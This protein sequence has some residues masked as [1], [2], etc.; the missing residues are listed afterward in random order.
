MIDF[1]RSIFNLIIRLGFVLFF[2]LIGF[3]V[4]NFF[5]WL[6]SGGLEVLHNS[7]TS[8]LIH[9]ITGF[10]VNSQHSETIENIFVGLVTILFALGY[11]IKTQE[12]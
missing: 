6:I 4:S 3:L 7:D 5:W 10:I 11:Y 9:S 12:D 1:L 8:D 2:G